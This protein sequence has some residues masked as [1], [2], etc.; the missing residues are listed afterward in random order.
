MLSCRWLAD[1]SNRIWALETRERPE[2]SGCF[3]A[4]NL[5]NSERH[6]QW[7][8][9][10]YLL[11]TIVVTLLN[12]TLTY[13]RVAKIKVLEI[14]MGSVFVWFRL[15]PIRC[16]RAAASEVFRWLPLSS[17]PWCTSSCTLW[18][19]WSMQLTVFPSISTR[20]WTSKWLWA[21]GTWYKPLWDTW[22]AVQKNNEKK[23]Q[24]AKL[25]RFST[26]RWQGWQGV[27]WFPRFDADVP[28][29]PIF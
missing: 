21:I 17:L 16:N 8:K 5:R 20:I 2:I 18:L 7:K 24:P 4:K 1:T 6:V 9:G 11:N 10:E 25:L 22:A 26:G 14:L 19:A 28:Q 12:F 23:I 15:S 3:M 27:F 13:G 29:V